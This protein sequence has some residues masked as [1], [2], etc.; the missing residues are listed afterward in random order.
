M[1]DKIPTDE[2]L[3]VRGCYLPSMCNF[4]CKNVES[5]FHIFF[6]C[7]FAIQLWSWLAKC[8]DLTLQFTCIE[9]MW[10]ITELNWS[11]QCK[12]TITAAIIN[13]LNTIWTIRNQARFDDKRISVDSAIS[14]IISNTSLSGNNTKKVASNSLRDFIILK[15]FNVAIH[16]PRMNTVKEVVWNPPLMNCV[17]CN[18]D[19]ASKGNPG[20]ASC[21]GIFRNSTADFLLCFAEP[22]GYASSFLAELHG[23]L[24]AIEVAH[25]MN[26]RHL[27]LETD[28]ELVVSAF[29]NPDKLVSWSLRNR[30]HNALFLIRQMNF[31][32]SHIFRE[33]NVAADSLANHGLVLNSVMFWHDPPDFIKVDLFKNKLGFANFRIVSC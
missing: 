30:W 8:L 32:V 3:L 18:I 16:N 24:R 13:L 20:E 19:G 11:P 23:A 22:L 6:E 15:K 5:S 26:W 28:S 31:V 7:G 12:L 2:H 25:Q 21:G 10:N 1:H 33:G 4:C 9:D 27:W 29:K 17:K 14:M